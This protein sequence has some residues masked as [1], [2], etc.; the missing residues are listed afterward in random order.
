MCKLNRHTKP[1]T[2]AD[3][4]KAAL[5]T[6]VATGMPVRT[7]QTA[8]MGFFCQLFKIFMEECLSDW[9]KI[10]VRFLWNFILF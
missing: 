10:K 6:C 2:S 9:I 3:R 1:Q 5:F 7:D 8:E 4:K